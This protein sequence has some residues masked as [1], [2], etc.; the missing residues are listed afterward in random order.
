ME[1]HCRNLV[2][3]MQ[4]LFKADFFFL[5]RD[6]HGALKISFLLYLFI[7]SYYCFPFL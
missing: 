4:F 7:L 1:L 6:I 3:K 2:K 5:K